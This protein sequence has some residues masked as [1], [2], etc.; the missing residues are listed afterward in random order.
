MLVLFHKLMGFPA[1]EG[2]GRMG[3]VLFPNVNPSLLSNLHS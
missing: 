1:G 2:A 3:G